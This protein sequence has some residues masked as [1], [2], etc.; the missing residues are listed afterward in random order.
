MKRL[1]RFRFTTLRILTAA[2]IFLIAMSAS[3]QGNHGRWIIKNVTDST[4]AHC[5][6]DS[7]TTVMFP[8]G[9]MAGM[10]MMPDSIYCRIDLMPLDSM[11]HPHD[12][13]FMGWHRMEIGR[14]STNFD[15]MKD[16]SGSGMSGC[17]QMGFAKPMR[18]CVRWDSTMSDSMHRSWSPKAIEGW[19]GTHWIAIPGVAIEGNSAKFTSSY[20]YPAIA[21][22]GVAKAV[23]G[24]RVGES[25]QQDFSLAQNYPNPFNPSTLIQFTLPSPENVILRVYNLLGVEVSTII[26]NQRLSQGVHSVRFDGTNLASGTYLYTVEAGPF[27]TTKKLQLIR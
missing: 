25:I 14:D 15:L 10:M 22:T 9:S 27:R 2:S 20:V 16:M 4:T 5:W 6:N 1:L 13:T 24:V 8:Q 3:A 12:S 17:G 19:D 18:F 7:G 26:N 23:L 11:V 21:I